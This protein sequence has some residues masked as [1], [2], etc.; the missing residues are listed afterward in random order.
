MLERIPLTPEG[1]TVKEAIHGID[2]A[3][4][5]G[6]PLLVLSF[7]SP[8]LESGHTPYVRDEHGVEALYDWWRRVFAY[9]SQRNV[10][11]TSVSGIL[12]ATLR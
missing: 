2:I 3:L 7:H 5:D 4:D 6:L 10:A 1:V 12:D 9:L 8:S 11:P